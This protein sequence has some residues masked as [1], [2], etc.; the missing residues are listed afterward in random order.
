MLV[1]K[2]G[3]QAYEAFFKKK[4]AAIEYWDKFPEQ[5]TAA[6]KYHR[7]VDGMSWWAT[8]EVWLENVLADSTESSENERE[9][10]EEPTSS[11]TSVQNEDEDDTGIEH[12]VLADPA[13]V[14]V[15]PMNKP[16]RKSSSKEGQDPFRSEQALP[17]RR[18]G[19]YATIQDAFEEKIRKLAPA[20]APPGLS[21]SDRPSP[22]DTLSP[23][24]SPYSFF[25]APPGLAGLS[26]AQQKVSKK[27]LAAGD[28]PPG[29]AKLSFTQRINNMLRMTLLD[30]APPTASKQLDAVAGLSDTAKP[31]SA[32]RF[33]KLLRMSA[34]NFDP[35][36]PTA[37]PSGLRIQQQHDRQ[38]PTHRPSARNIH[39]LAAQLP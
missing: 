38:P 36:R 3:I 37:P 33:D 24:S 12:F 4:C 6:W 21:M 11:R 5:Y 20:F 13:V 31:P 19:S 10:S 16:H 1:A 17:I 23:L 35:D 7:N 26:L 28:G 18:R 9:S 15:V 22:E 2:E 25:A 8:R 39:P 14:K 29:L 30:T 34:L 32:W 27:Q